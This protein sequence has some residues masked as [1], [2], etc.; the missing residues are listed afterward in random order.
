MPNPYEYDAIKAN[1][2]NTHKMLLSEYLK[3]MKNINNIQAS[4]FDYCCTS[5]GKKDIKP[6][7][8]LKQFFNYHI[9]AKNSLLAVT[10]CW[11]NSK[12]HQGTYNDFVRLASIVTRGA[13]INGYNACVL[14]VGRAYKGS[15]FYSLFHI[16]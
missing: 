10:L 1:H 7:D 4:I 2:A 9:P 16:I 15:M 3:S 14:P 5:D 13:H 12:N 6:I 11:R 8:D